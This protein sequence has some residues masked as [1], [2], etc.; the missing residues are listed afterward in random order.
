MKTWMKLSISFAVI[1]ASCVFVMYGSPGIEASAND[2]SI[3]AQSNQTA[4]SRTPS[5][6][7]SPAP[8]PRGQ[9]PTDL[10]RASK[11]PP[12]PLPQYGNPEEG[13][14]P[15]KQPMT[16][17][18]PVVPPPG[19]TMCI[20]TNSY[21][22]QI[23]IIVPEGSS[24][25]T[26]ADG[27]VTVT[28]PCA[29]P[30]C[31][32]LLIPA[33]TSAGILYSGTNPVIIVPYYDSTVNFAPDG[34]YGITL[35]DGRVYTLPVPGR[36]RDPWFWFSP[37]APLP[38]QYPVVSPSTESVMFVF[39]DADGNQIAIFAP[40]GSTFVLNP[41]GSV[42]VHL[43]GGTQY[44]IPFGT[45][46]AMITTAQGWPIIVVPYLGTTITSYGIMGYQI[47]LPDGTSYWDTN[48]F[49]R[50]YFHQPQTPPLPPGL[51]LSVATF[52]YGLYFPG[53]PP[54]WSGIL[55]VVGVPGINCFGYRTGVKIE[56]PDGYS[57]VM[58]YP[59]LPGAYTRTVWIDPDGIGG[60]PGHWVT[61]HFAIILQGSTVT[62]LGNGWYHVEPPAGS[63]G[64]P[65]DFQYP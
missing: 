28:F 24:C 53:L 11:Q 2:H 30:P 41:D 60:Q 45:T 17:G 21:G 13:R 26:N 31:P 40:R 59:V 27:S 61:Y 49:T 23:A 3:I 57:Y 8:Q 65:F 50:F 46:F 32:T 16:H 58:P 6:Q 18:V 37:P 36:N 19:M 64:Q 25:H 15:Y 9:Q 22:Q 33:Y 56:F 14:P 47:T 48:I 38:L 10:P 4:P 55:Q 39:T 12:P 63:G 29:V 52:T 1:I 62:S 7:P 51:G 54:A 34:G 44:T 5:Q 35:P 20:F 43:P 42:T